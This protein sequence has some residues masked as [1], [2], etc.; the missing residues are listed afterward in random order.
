MDIESNDSH[1]HPM[2]SDEIWGLMG[3]SHYYTYAWSSYWHNKNEDVAI[4]WDDVLPML[5]FFDQIPPWESRTDTKSPRYEIR[6]YGARDL[7][8]SPA[9]S[10]GNLVICARGIIDKDTA[11][12][13][14]PMPLT[15]SDNP[16][17]G[18]GTT[19]YQFVLPIDRSAISSQPTTKP[20][21]K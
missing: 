20:S 5:T 21:G 11:T 9:L 16:V 19:I 2:G 3:G 12:T 13:P 6:R 1:R 18:N 17:A 8:L 10:A 14:L 4:D 7:N 15:V